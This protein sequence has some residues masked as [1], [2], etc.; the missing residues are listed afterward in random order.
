MTTAM[1]EQYPGS[2]MLLLSFVVSGFTAGVVL[3]VLDAMSED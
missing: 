2:V 3:L 1:L